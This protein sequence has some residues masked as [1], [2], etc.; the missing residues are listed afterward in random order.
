[1]NRFS[2][3]LFPAVGFLLAAPLAAEMPGRGL[4]QIL[5]AE[6]AKA[7]VQVQPAPLVDDLAYLRK[8]SV[9]LIG[10]IPTAGE[11][12]EYLA[13]PKATRREQAVEKLLADERFSVRWTAFFADMLRLRTNAEGGAALTAFVHKSLEDRMPYDE[14]ARRLISAGGKSGAVPEVGYILSDNADP[15]ALA[16]ITSQVFLGVRMACAECHDHPFDKWTREDFYGFAAYFGKTRRIERRFNNRILATYTTE[17]NQTAVLWPPPGIDDDN[18]K[19]VP[20]KFPVALVDDSRSLAYI[21]RLRQLRASKQKANSAKKKTEKPAEASI[22][23]LLA[24]AADRAERRTAG[25]IDSGLG[26]LEEAKKD[27]Q[28]I[29]VNE[30]GYQPSEL[31]EELARLITHPR[32][33]YFSRAFVN[34]VW[35]ELVGLGF[36]EPIDDFSDSNP[37]HHAETLNDLAE[38]F[39]ANGYDL[40][41]LV[42]RIVTSEAYQRSHAESVDE[43]T[44]LDMEQAFLATPMRRMISETLYDSI[45]TAGHLFDAK[46]AAGKNMKVVWQQTRVMK[47]PAEGGT[48]LDTAKIAQAKPAK[49]A[50]SNG[51]KPAKPKAGYDLERA[52]EVD[53]NQI[54]KDGGD[55]AA[56]V[57]K[58]VAKSAEEIEAERMLAE[59]QKRQAEYFDRFVKTVIDDNPKFTSAFL[60]ASPA[61]PEHFLR[62]FGQPGR[63]ELGDF[64]DESATMR[65]QLMILNGRLVNEASRVGEKEPM[66]GLLAGKTAD[67]KEA[68]ELAYQEILTRRPTAEEIQMAQEVVKASEDQLAGMADLRWV[69]LNSNEFRF[70]P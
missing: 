35:K 56:M 34:R 38:E 9:D 45:V 19:P 6:N 5:N 41:M 10:R 47:N 25:D 32:N 65:Q 36:V 43:S 24:S 31:R 48:K 57:D 4:D 33:R 30:A 17:V 42:Q 29:N 66:Y 60:M 40:R 27:V 70:L 64:R 58:M 46:H 20:P 49:P 55:D 52:I 44:R 21:D 67:L 28:K 2:L 14:L 68:I 69:L 3:C 62:V 63:S 18:R 13:W 53:F 51:K 61:P 54:L 8:V 11:I 26:V 16:G 37:P 12:D 23:D 39:V 15:L 50:M 59:S 1:M 7:G 22:D